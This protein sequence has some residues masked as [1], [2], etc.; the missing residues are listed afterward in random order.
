MTAFRFAAL[1]MVVL[2]A[3]TIAEAHDPNLHEG[4]FEIWLDE[5]NI[6]HTEPRVVGSELSAAYFFWTDEPGFDSH[7]GAFPAGS[8]VGFNILETL[9]KWN[10]SGF[11]VLDPN[12]EETLTVSYLFGTEFETR[13]TS[14]GFVA[15]FDIPVASDGSW[16]KHLGYGLNGIGYGEPRNGMYLLELELY[17]TGSGIIKSDAFWI[18]FNLGMSE[19]DHHEAI[20]R[21]EEN[22]VQPPDVY[23]DGDIDFRDLA[24]VAGQWLKGNCECVN[25]W[26][27]GADITENGK[28]DFADFGKLAS[29]WQKSA[30]GEQDE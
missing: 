2:L 15:G 5:C 21:V 13:D 20:H 18:V 10:G 14:S 8:S 30:G 23:Q 24:I 9:K 12:T 1:L 4:D 11:D 27:N 28:V 3:C 29:H 6:I 17:S 26:C 19:E 7:T 22:L 25:G 16:H